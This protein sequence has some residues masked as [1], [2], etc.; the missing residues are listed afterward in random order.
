VAPTTA[1][2]PPRHSL[3][4][5]RAQAHGHLRMTLLVARPS[6]PRHHNLGSPRG[7]A[8]QA[9]ELAAPDLHDARVRPPLRG[10]RPHMVCTKVGP[11][12]LHKKGGV[13]PPAGDGGWSQGPGW[14]WR[15]VAGGLG[16]ETLAPGYICAPSPIGPNWWPKSRMGPVSFQPG[17]VIIGFFIFKLANL[18]Y[19]FIYIEFIF[20]SPNYIN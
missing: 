5:G 10:S 13:I 8:S 1:G 11:T 14:R 12:G 15:L 6:T 20:H 2:R 9:R 16:L 19:L 17:L 4:R 3:V 18:V 7:R